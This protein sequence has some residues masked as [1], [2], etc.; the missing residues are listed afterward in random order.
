MLY[1][2]YRCD[3]QKFF[4]RFRE[5]CQGE[6]RTDF[7]RSEVFKGWHN[8]RYFIQ[9]VHNLEEKY[10]CGGITE[11]EWGRIEKKWFKWIAGD[12]VFDS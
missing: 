4:E 3:F 10:D 2:G 9:C 12:V 1:R 7:D 6:V 8:D 11:E 5:A